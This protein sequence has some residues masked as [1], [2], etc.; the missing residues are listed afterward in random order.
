MVKTV[1]QK[2]G[3]GATAWEV[4]QFY[5]KMWEVLIFETNQNIL[6]PFPFSGNFEHKKTLCHRS[7]RGF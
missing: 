6:N 1:K 3:R 4:L 7:Y 5:P 2:S